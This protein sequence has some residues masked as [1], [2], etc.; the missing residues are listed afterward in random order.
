VNQVK[1]R[2]DR[3]RRRLLLTVNLLWYIRIY[4]YM[5]KGG[6]PHVSITSQKG[7]KRMSLIIS[8]ELHRAFKVATAAEGKEM[9]E[10]LIAFIEE[11]V[12]KHSPATR[13]AKKGGR[14]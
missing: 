5:T 2:F 7:Y 13:P 6:D 14:S 4:I 9:S 8:P 1:G 12:R 10:V 11:Y 3:G